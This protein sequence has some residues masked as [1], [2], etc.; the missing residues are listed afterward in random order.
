VQCRGAAVQ[1]GGA[2]AVQQGEAAAVQ[3]G[4]VWHTV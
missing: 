2:S 1:Q 4:R 3:K